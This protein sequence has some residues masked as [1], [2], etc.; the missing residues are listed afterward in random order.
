MNIAYVLGY[1]GAE[2]GGVPRMALDLGEA[3]NRLGH[4]V[5]YWA[6]GNEEHIREFAESSLSVNL[7]NTVWPKGWFHSPDLARELMSQVT[8]FDLLH[9]HGTWTHPIY[10]GAKITWKTGTPCLLTP[11]GTLEPWRLQ[12]GRLKKKLYLALLGR[13]IFKSVKCLHA[14]STCE[15][16]H[17]RMVGY[18]GP[19]TIIPSGVNVRE[20][21]TLPDRDEAED[22]W[23]VLKDRRVV[24]F[25]S[26]LSIE[27]GLD[28]LIPLWA[29][30]VKSVTYKDALLIIAGPDDRGYKKVVDRT[31]DRFCVGSKILI[32]GMVRGWEKLLLLRRA[33]IFIL[34]SYSENFGIVVLEALACGTP[35]ITT[36]G[37]PWRELQDLNVG[38]WVPPR[39]PELQ[40][41]LRELL[42]ISDSE[43]EAMGC[44]GQRLVSEKYSWDKIARQFITI[45]NCM[46]QGK[47]IPLYPEPWGLNIE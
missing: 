25:M 34:P 35:V 29:D 24:L 45:Y 6:T 27:K 12:K 10:A 37:T 41:A 44:R 23:P 3:L 11:H 17:F 47:D 31:I 30:L 21:M 14:L 19:I 40:Q 36:T 32:V 8:S 7:L 9:L 28:L 33:D 46:L 4:C 20:N 43:R 22:R 16:E 26:R 2:F 18:T 13:R 39:I 5:S 42:E 38:R 15:A 1:L